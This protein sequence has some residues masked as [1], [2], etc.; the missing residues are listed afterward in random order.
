MNERLGLIDNGRHDV[1]V[2]M[3]EVQD[4]NATHKIDVALVIFVP[5]FCIFTRTAL[6]EQ[7]LY[8]P[9]RLARIFLCIMIVPE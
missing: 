8:P 2:A 4:P 7:V 1:R 6:W 9:G 5:N 3:S